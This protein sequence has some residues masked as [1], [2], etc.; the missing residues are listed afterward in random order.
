MLNEL[1]EL[2]AL[3]QAHSDHSWKNSW[4]G[5]S[6]QFDLLVCLLQHWMDISACIWM[7]VF[8]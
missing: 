6:M 8:I 4:S 1:N 3:A 7:E 5:G 2:I